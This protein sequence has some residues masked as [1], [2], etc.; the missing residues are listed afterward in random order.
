MKNKII[1]NNTEIKHNDKIISIITPKRK[2]SKKQIK[3]IIKK[4]NQEIILI[5]TKIKYLD[6]TKK[7]S[8]PSK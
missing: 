1:I 8:S 5:E 7:I 2:R 4:I 3:K 6:K